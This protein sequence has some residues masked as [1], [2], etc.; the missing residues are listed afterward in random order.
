VLDLRGRKGSLYE[1]GIRQPLILYWPGHVQAG[2]RDD[3][4]VAQAVD[5]LPTLAAIAGAK[6]PAGGEGV[7]LSPVLSGKP[8]A[9]RPLLFWAFG[10]PGAQRQPNTPFNPHDKAPPV[11]VRDGRW[12]LLAEADGSGAE[13]YDL[14]ADPGETRN[15]A[16][17]Q[18]AI[19]TRLLGRL[20]AWAGTLHP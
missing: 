1:G 13:L 2:H 20:R 18:P 19:S 10:M 12:K 15:V 7:D 17:S 6:A 11:A 9:Q 4:T 3:R 8:I 16:A 5:L 14:E